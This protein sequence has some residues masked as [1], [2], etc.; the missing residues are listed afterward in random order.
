MLIFFFFLQ[1]DYFVSEHEEDLIETLQGDRLTQE[2]MEEELCI[3]V[4]GTSCL[5]V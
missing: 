4:T 1:C 3:D 5:H 2:D